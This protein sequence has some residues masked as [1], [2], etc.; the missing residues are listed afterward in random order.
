MRKMSLILVLFLAIQSF[1]GD[2]A[3]SCDRIDSKIATF[4]RMKTAGMVLL[5]AS[6]VGGVMAIQ[7]MTRSNRQ[8]DG[9]AGEA[10]EALQGVMLIELSVMGAIAGGILTGIG[11]KKEGNYRRLLEEQNCSIFLNPARKQIGLAYRF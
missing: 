7:L 5:G 8:N 10:F 6:A 11:A 4:S 9:D 3:Y 1:A 2:F